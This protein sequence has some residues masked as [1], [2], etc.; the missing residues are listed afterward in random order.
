MQTFTVIIERVNGGYLARWRG[1]QTWAIT[2]AEA[3]TEI[4]AIVD[5]YNK[6]AKA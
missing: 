3:I 6:T 2:R 4:L 5:S 1:N